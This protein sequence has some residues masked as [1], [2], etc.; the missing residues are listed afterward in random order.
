MKQIT[1]RPT[2]ILVVVCLAVGVC[3]SLAGAANSARETPGVKAAELSAG[4]VINGYRQWTQVN[5]TPNVFASRIAIQCAA[6]NPDQFKMEAAN[7]HRDKYIVVYVNDVGRHA[8]MQEKVPHF[9]EG[10]VIV[11]EKLPAKDSRTPELLT[12]M[13]KRESGYNPQSGDWEYMALDGTGKEVQARG[14]LANCQACHL[15]HKDSD[16]VSRNYLP[17]ELWKKLR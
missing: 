5:P 6:P 4:E 11:K 1:N 14:R 8:M 7:P 16:Y 13:M 15:M 10:S 17:Y 3:T 2:K 9:P 12:V